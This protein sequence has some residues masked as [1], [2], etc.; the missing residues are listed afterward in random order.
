METDCE[1]KKKRGRWMFMI[2]YGVMLYKMHPFG[3]W[4]CL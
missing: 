4:Y 1:P 3:R 2:P